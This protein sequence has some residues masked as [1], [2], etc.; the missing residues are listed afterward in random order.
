M[1][2]IRNPLQ[3]EL[4]LKI[5]LQLAGSSKPT[6]VLVVAALL[7]ASGVSGNAWWTMLQ[8]LPTW[9][10]S[11]DGSLFLELVCM[12]LLPTILLSLWLVS[13]TANE[14]VRVSVGQ[15][16]NPQ[17]VKAL[18]LFL[19]PVGDDADHVQA[20]LSGSPAM[21]LDNRSDREKF[22]R[23]W[24]MP[25]EAIAYHLLRLQYVVVI[26]SADYVTK[27]GLVA[28]T[29]HD[30][31]KFCQITRLLLPANPGEPCPQ[32]LGIPALQRICQD[33]WGKKTVVR[34]RAT[35]QLIAFVQDLAGRFGWQE[36]TPPRRPRPRPGN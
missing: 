15:E 1:A 29:W 26:P 4:A 12:M 18:V 33:A 28:G 5:I 3:K 35:N 19:S 21:R 8:R 9:T 27:K 14:R 22:Q 2:T 34:E 30:L 10:F 25:L 23:S 24:R 36:P 20:I 17:P 32:I 16:E 7:I 11:L 13:R 31:E 6:V